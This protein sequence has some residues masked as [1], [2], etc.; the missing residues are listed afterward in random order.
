MSICAVGVHIA[1]TYYNI[2]AVL[3]SLSYHKHYIIVTSLELVKHSPYKNA[4][5]TG[6]YAHKL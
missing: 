3:G 6:T 2:T 1:I 4:M 5:Y